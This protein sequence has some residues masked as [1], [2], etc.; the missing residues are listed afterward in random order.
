MVTLTQWSWAGECPTCYTC[1]D[2][3]ATRCERD[4]VPLTP[5]P[6]PRYLDGRYRLDQRIGQGGMGAVYE[7]TDTSLERVVAIK[8]IREE[9][10]GRAEAA[11]RF[12]REARATAGF[13]HRHAVTVHDFGVVPGGVPFLV[14]ERLH[15]H[16]L[17]DALADAPGLG[18]SRTLA[19]LRGVCAAVEAAHA[20]QLIHLDLKPANIFLA[21]ADGEEVVKV[22]DFGLAKFLSASAKTDPETQPGLVV[23]TV[24]YMAPERFLG[25]DASTRWDVWSL[26]VVA[27][28]MLAGGRP[29]AGPS[30]SRIQM[31]IMSGKMT[32]LA[33]YLPAAP[34]SWHAFFERALAR[35]PDQ[36]PDTVRQLYTELEG[37]LAP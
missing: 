21:Q 1:Y 6:C 9:L 13:S 23:G 25:E 15:G 4:G 32:L 28:E 29:F 16:S 26:A 12:Q 14:M 17:H 2:P 30:A 8:V 37:L 11:G 33:T 10:A 24:A 22:L 18:P 36:R 3:G 34:A 35:D 20:H 31:D 7:A 19:I 5:M 27:Y